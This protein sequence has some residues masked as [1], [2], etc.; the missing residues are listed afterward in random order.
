MPVL[1][2]LSDFASELRFA[3]IPTGLVQDI[4]MH[5][6]DTIGVC[7]ASTQL[8]YARAVAQ[9][10]QREGGAGSAT[11]FGLSG[12][13]PTESAGFYNACL[14]HGTDFDDSHLA[15]IAHPSAT[16]LPP[17]LAIAEADGYDGQ[18]LVTALVTGIEVMC[19]VGVAAG[20]ALLARGIH[21]TSSCGAFGAAAAIAKL[22]GLDKAG[23]TSA[24]GLAGGMTG[25]IHQSTID[26]SWNKC[27][28]SGLAAQAGFTAVALAQSGMTGPRSILDGETGFFASFAG[29]SPDARSGATA[30]LGDSWEAARLAYKPYPCCQ[31]VQPYA[32]CALDLR[33][34]LADA[35]EIDRIDV[36]IGALVG[37]RLCEPSELKSRPPTPYAA[38][39]SIPYVIA[40]AL[41]HGTVDALSFTETAIADPAVLSLAARVRYA[42]DPYYDEG[43]ALRG[44]VAVRLADGRVMTRETAACRGT[45]E[46]PW[47]A[48]DVVGKFRRNADPILGAARAEAL[49]GLVPRMA[50]LRDPGE[51]ARICQG[52]AEA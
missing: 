31:G 2:R 36:A 44:R 8:P 42:V 28:H 14:G 18:A 29:V 22:A 41:I 33:P 11:A 25:G 32:D 45:P 49:A 51:I 26:G 15:A 4:C 17:L 50:Q 52:A 47:A 23:I 43:M 39:F 30:G 20:P 9:F 16:I 27:I 5:A 38:K 40:S 3:D 37:L 21:P 24:M 46:N 7:L 12:S 6:L 34:G 13:Y 35:G 48:V 10:I 1:D 19:R